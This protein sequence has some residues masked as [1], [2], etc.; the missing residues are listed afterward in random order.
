MSL[1][2]PCPR[3]KTRQCN[4]F[5]RL[6]RNTHSMN[7][8]A[9]DSNPA[10]SLAEWVGGTSCR[11]TEVQ[12]TL[13]RFAFAHLLTHTTKIT[14]WQGNRCFS[15]HPALWN[16]RLW[17]APR[18]QRPGIVRD[19]HRPA[20]AQQERCAGS[21]RGHRKSPQTSV[22]APRSPRLGAQYS[23]T[24]HCSGSVRQHKQAHHLRR[25]SLWSWLDQHV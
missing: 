2:A 25:C 23:Y 19:V 12:N 13:L 22:A 11:I 16:T 6:V 24:C 18:T 14:R 20:M 21:Y 7:T 17:H 4:S 1:H 5:Q 15:C 8:N 9:L 10:T 3:Q